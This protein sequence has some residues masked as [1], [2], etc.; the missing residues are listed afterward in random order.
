MSSV[1]DWTKK[2]VD[3]AKHIVEEKSGEEATEGE[4]S[5]SQSTSAA[6]APSSEDSAA[7][8]QIV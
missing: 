8:P 3:T 2:T 7:K 5:N 6:P 1:W 4:G